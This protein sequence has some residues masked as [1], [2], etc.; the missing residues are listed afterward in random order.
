MLRK[1]LLLSAALLRCQPFTLRGLVLL[2]LSL[3]ATFIL[4][5]PEMDLVAAG[6][7]GSL[8]ALLLVSMLCGLILRV[9]LARSIQVE[10]FFD[11]TSLSSKSA[12]P[13]GLLIRQAILP[14]CFLLRV[15]R[16]F[17]PSGADSPLHLIKGS[18]RSDTVHHLIDHVVFPH[19]GL[20]TLEF[21]KFSIGDTLGLVSYSWLLRLDQALEVRPPEVPI[22]PLPVRASSSRA[23][24]EL[25]MSQTRTG[26]LFDIKQYDP[27]DGTKKILWKTFAKSRQL[28]VR[29]P[30][31]ALIPEGE[32]A[33]YLIADREDDHV[34]GAALNY[35]NYLFSNQIGVIFGTDNA[36]VEKDTLPQRPGILCSR[37]EDISSIV[38]RT[39]GAENA[40]TAL[41]LLSFLEALSR[42]EHLFHSVLIIAPER[43]L[44]FNSLPRQTASSA[45]KRFNISPIIAAVPENLPQR[46]NWPIIQGQTPSRLRAAKSVIMRT[47]ER[48]FSK[49]IVK[50]YQGRED[51]SM[52][53]IFQV[54]LRE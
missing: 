25:N 27:S 8:L 9:K 28:V 24:D 45:C 23:G 41:G 34:A 39:A 35:I 32:L 17:S 22:Q 6:L 26:D 37:A 51:A 13:S 15:E 44:E 52:E 47:K 36:G 5:L 30:E 48:L 43:L 33:I 7:G 31:P 50:P 2:A 29:R 18:S 1:S 46:L 38:A 19:R 11:Q 10:S 42:S 54:E 16:S 53:Q 4:A 20:W 12:T 40:G 21:L 3:Y 49:N 14:P